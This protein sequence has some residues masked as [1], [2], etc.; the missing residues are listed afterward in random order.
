VK[1][2]HRIIVALSGGVDSSVAAFLLK[3]AGH[4]VI[5]LYMRNWHDETLTKNN[6]CP[7]I[8]D[9]NYALEV[10]DQIGIPFQILDLSTEYKERIINYMTSS[11]KKGL[12]PNPDI[13]CNKKIKFDVFLEHA[14]KLKADFIATG[15]YCIKGKINDSYTIKE[16]R[17]KS[18]DQTY[19][20]CQINQ[21]QLKKSLFPI[22]KLTKKEVRDIAHKNNLV[23]ANKKDSQG[24]CFVGK[25]K[26]PV[27]LQNQLKAKKGKI[28]E[29]KSNSEI[30][31]NKKDESEDF[32]YQMDYG[33]Q[34]GYHNGA[35]FFTIGQRKGLEIGGK[36]EPLFVIGTCVKK[37]LVFVG[38]GKKHPG[39]FRRILKIEIK[40][41][42]WIRKESKMKLNDKKE[43]KVRIRHRQ[44]LQD[45]TL[46]LTNKFLLI[47]FKVAQR[48]I[49]KGQFAAWYHQSELI[50]SGEIN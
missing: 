31:K 34:I 19:F 33:D 41:T 11:Y 5:G 17:D 3:E 42:H 1:K 35:H 30:Y 38:M 39:L 16:G 49:A 46:E 26:L 21:A 22:G 20:L 50:G 18:K 14:M 28:I 8:E 25:I 29:I 48:A 47:K 15:H 27:F 6:E 44:K 36:K 2:K 13:L 32:N 10:A 9:S 23:T 37:N 4:E 24:L 12:T 45:A 7:W 40:K 43:Y